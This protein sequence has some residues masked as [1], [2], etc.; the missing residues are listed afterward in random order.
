MTA[1]SIT[2]N[3]GTESMKICTRQDARQTLLDTPQT[4]M[5]VISVRGPEGI[6]H[7]QDQVIGAKIHMKGSFD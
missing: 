1:L 4:S 2:K 5:R 6:N 7:V 3:K